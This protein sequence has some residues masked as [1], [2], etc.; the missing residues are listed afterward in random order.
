M[1]GGGL[2]RMGGVRLS[3]EKISPISW[4]GIPAVAPGEC[5]MAPILL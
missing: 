1:E 2:V 3:G 4:L 5:F